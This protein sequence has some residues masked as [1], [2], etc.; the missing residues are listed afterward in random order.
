MLHRL[1]S[2]PPFFVLCSSCVNNVLPSIKNILVHEEH[3]TKKRSDETKRCNIMD[4]LNMVNNIYNTAVL[5]NGGNDNGDIVVRNER[6]QVSVV[7]Y[8]R[9]QV[10]FNV[11]YFKK[12]NY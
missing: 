1:V 3:K 4:M 8:E 7:G 2:S 9:V 5:G 12:K 11:Y 10:N 6:V